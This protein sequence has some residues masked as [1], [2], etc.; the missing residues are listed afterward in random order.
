MRFNIQIHK[1]VC[2]LLPRSLLSWLEHFLEAFL[3]HSGTLFYIA[4]SCWSAILRRRRICIHY[5]AYGGGLGGWIWFVGP[6]FTPS[7]S[8]LLLASI[9]AS[10]SHPYACCGYGALCVSAGWAVAVWKSC[11]YSLH[12][13]STHDHLPKLVCIHRHQLERKLL[14]NEAHELAFMGL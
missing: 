11:L 3:C 6:P 7:I 14:H 8:G 10:S 5:L 9:K 1:L 13:Y 2:C 12:V 4:L